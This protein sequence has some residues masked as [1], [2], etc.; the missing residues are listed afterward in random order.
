MLQVIAPAA[1]SAAAGGSVRNV[2]T[3]TTAAGAATREGVHEA[4]TRLV[5]SRRLRGHLQPPVLDMDLLTEVYTQTELSQGGMP[6]SDSML[7]PMNN[8]IIRSI[9]GCTCISDLEHV[10]NRELALMHSASTA[11]A[12]GTLASF[13]SRAA[14]RGRPAAEGPPSQGGW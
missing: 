12:L 14:L 3:T 1:I 8:H 10:I 9:K 7:V 11:T 6:A 5:R 4:A 2:V 13:T